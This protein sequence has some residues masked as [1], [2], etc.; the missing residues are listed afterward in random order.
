[1][2]IQAPAHG[3]TLVELMVTV[4]LIA[5]MMAIAAPG[6]VTF[7]RNSELTSLAN[8]LLAAINTARGEA[9]KRGSYATVIPVDGADWGS[10]CLVFIDMDRN[11]AY[12]SATDKQIYVSTALPSYLS[13]RA[14][15]TA[16]PGSPHISFDASGFSSPLSSTV[17]LELSRNDVDAKDYSQI[18][19]IKVAKTG[20]VRV[21]TPSSEVD[22]TCPLLPTKS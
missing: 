13:V 9:M 17:T 2:K 10:G 7:Q 21:C 12:D 1:M 16:G 22:S 20:R 5:I 4:A 11:S 6:Y 15:G 3:F 14:N 18:R 8:G 19:S